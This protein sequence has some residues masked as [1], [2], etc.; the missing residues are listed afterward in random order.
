[1]I[2]S[3]GRNNEYRIFIAALNSIYYTEI[4]RSNNLVM[5]VG[6]IADVVL[7]GGFS[8][9]IRIGIFRSNNKG[10]LSK[11]GSFGSLN[12]YDE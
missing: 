5:V 1:M 7:A 10:H 2:L 9:N 12:K 3:R 11:I 4:M 8:L 6:N